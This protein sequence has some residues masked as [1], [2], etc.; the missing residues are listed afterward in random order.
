M[1]DK[2][3]N[4]PQLLAAALVG[5][6]LLVIISAGLKSNS[7]N[8]T[9]RPADAIKEITLKTPRATNIA[10]I[11]ITTS[12][13]FDFTYS[14]SNEILKIKPISLLGHGQQYTVTASYKD[15]NSQD[16]SVKSSFTYKVPGKA[17]LA[18]DKQTLPGNGFD[19]YI[20]DRFNFRVFIT[21]P[22][23]DETKAVIEAKKV[24]KNYGIDP[25][26]VEFTTELSRSAREDGVNL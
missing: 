23:L 11:Q 5:A 16:L 6:V 22:E 24:L 26:S 21:I 7:S 13:N 20:K 15:Q 10:E 19:I 18:L 17:G 1:I 8:N 12:P 14:F 2:L 3:R 4:N 9:D 25:E